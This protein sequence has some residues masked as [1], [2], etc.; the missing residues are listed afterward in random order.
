MVRCLWIT[1]TIVTEIDAFSWTC[2]TVAP[3]P[4]DIA[5]FDND[6]ILD[7]ISAFL[8]TVGVYSGGSFP[9]LYSVSA[10]WPPSSSY[11]QESYSHRL[12]IDSRVSH[13]M[14]HL[15]KID[16]RICNS[17]VSLASYCKWSLARFGAHFKAQWPRWCC[18][19]YCLQILFI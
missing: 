7:E 6:P 2:P 11:D 17:A 5:L 18:W 4:F 9:I 16:Y 14:L 10:I 3:R 1:S 13:C 12:P 19:I 8:D 15:L